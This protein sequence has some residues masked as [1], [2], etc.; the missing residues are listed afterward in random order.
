MSADVRKPK[1]DIDDFWDEFDWEELSPGEQKLFAALGW[2]EESWDD[3]GDVPSSD[4]DWEEL[5]PKEQAALTALGYDEEY[6]DS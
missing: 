3:D 6:W 4:K 2:D 5:S 1:G